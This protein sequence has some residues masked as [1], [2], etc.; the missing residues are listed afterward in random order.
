MNRRTETVPDEHFEALYRDDPDPW[1]FATSEYELGKYGATL[2]AI[3]AG[4]VARAWE[5]GCSIGVF[6]RSLADICDSLLA[7]DV[8]ETALAQARERCADVPHVELQRLRIPDQ[9]P[10]GKFDLIVFSEVL[11]YL[12][13]DQLRE[14]ARRSVLS[15]SPGGRIVTVHW[16]GE[17]DDPLSGDEAAKLFIEACRDQ[18]ALVHHDRQPQYRLDV[19]QAEIPTA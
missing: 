11:Y 10:A 7:V 3:G 2:A 13:P 15:L 16:T 8:S 4:R 17:T 14:V 1:K 9:W 19:L 6:T 18:L 5:V 12:V